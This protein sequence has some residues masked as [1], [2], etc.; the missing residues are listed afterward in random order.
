[1]GTQPPPPHQ[2]AATPPALS[3]ASKPSVFGPD[4]A[5]VAS[6]WTALSLVP[7]LSAD[8]ALAGVIRI[9]SQEL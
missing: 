2:P 3:S 4:P 9:S 5:R 1:M 7:A 8:L 6:P